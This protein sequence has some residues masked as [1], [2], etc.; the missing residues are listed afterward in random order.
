MSR[1]PGEVSLFRKTTAKTA[2][3]WMR[4]GLLLVACRA[5]PA[6]CAPWSAWGSWGARVPGAQPPNLKVVWQL[7]VSC[8]TFR[9]GLS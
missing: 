2:L 5:V 3:L 7:V 1:A 4:S 9:V 6:A 8:P